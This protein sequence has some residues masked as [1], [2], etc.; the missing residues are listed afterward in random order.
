[1]AREI[2]GIERDALALRRALDLGIIDSAC[3][4]EVPAFAGMTANADLVMLAVPVAQTG[5]VLADL[6]QHLAP[7]AIVTDA[8]STKSD[9]AAAARAALGDRVAQ[10]IPGHPIAGRE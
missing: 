10:F 9:V 2:V 7:G 4:T 6:L 3:T 5:R 8:G 1:M